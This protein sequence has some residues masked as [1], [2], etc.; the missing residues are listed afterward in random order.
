MWHY[1]KAKLND[2][3]PLGGLYERVAAADQLGY[4]VVLSVAEEGL[5]VHYQKRPDTSDIEAI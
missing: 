4:D 3:W 5:R 2:G 1:P